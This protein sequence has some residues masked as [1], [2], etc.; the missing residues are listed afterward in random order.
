ML[1]AKDQK[2]LR[3]LRSRKQRWAQQL[4]IA[5]GPKLIAD[6]QASGLTAYKLWSTQAAAGEEA[7][8][9][10][11]LRAWSQLS[12]PHQ[13]LAIFPFPRVE[14]APG[15][16]CLILDAINDPGNLGTLLRSAEWF[17]F[18]QIFCTPGTADVYNA[19]TVQ[20]TMGSIGRVAVHYREREAIAQNLR[21]SH[22][23]LC[24]D[25]M[26]KP[27]GQY[28]ADG[29][30]PALVL[31]SESHGPDPFWRSAAEAYTIPKIGDS[32]I[33]SLNVAVAGSLFMQILSAS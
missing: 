33:E 29:R 10:A 21:A 9:E 6:L 2:L 24:A 14:L 30:P 16:P 27:L 15:G 18:R 8:S 11:E 19:K 5:E 20:S 4:F 7:I 26:A 32:P 31:G 13:Q 28:R 17:G 25:M 23:L 3:K 12:T 1:S 22:R